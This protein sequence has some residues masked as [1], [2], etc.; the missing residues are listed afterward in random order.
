MEL[1]DRISSLGDRVPSIESHLTTE[2]ATKTSLVMPF[3]QSLG[4]DVFNPQEVV[5]EFTAD[6]GIKRGEKVDYALMRDGA[7][8]VLMECKRFGSCLNSHGSQLFRYF[9]TTPA[10]IGILCDGVEYRFFSD[11]EQPN[12]MDEQPFY[13]M[14]I[15][16][17]DEHAISFL[18]LLSKKQ[19][20][21]DAIIDRAYQ[22][23]D[24]TAI[25]MLL[26]QEFAEPSDAFIR[27]FANQLVDGRVTQ[28]V[29][30]RFRP[31]VKQAITELVTSKVDARLRDALATNSA[32]VV[33]TPVS[34]LAEPQ[35]TEPEPVCDGEPD[36]IV[37]TLDELAGLYIVKAIL[38]DHVDIRRVVARDVQSYF[39]I[40]LDDNNRK[41]ICRLWFNGGKKYIGVFDSD[42]REER[43]P[44]SC[45][46]D[47]FLHSDRVRESLLCALGVSLTPPAQPDT[48]P[49]PPEG[50]PA[51]H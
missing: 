15:T 19:F 12:R 22:I 45:P 28:G 42:K 26:N 48:S 9:G 50:V 49:S 10:R 23:K 20:D 37:T 46:E 31:N 29:L 14:R 32:I 40:L 18:T 5:P 51:H 17:I 16:K 44:V 27:H 30:D 34:P 7:P 47:I 13:S 43:L 21:I 38:R 2:E 11:L 33:D 39:G 4:F 1:A 6:V 41:P 8:I 25:R 36:A 3:L 24:K 35:N